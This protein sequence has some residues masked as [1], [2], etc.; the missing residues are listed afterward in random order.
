MVLGQVAEEL[1][2]ICVERADGAG[3]NEAVGLLSATAIP[4]VPRVA[5]DIGSGNL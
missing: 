5:P 2:D 4:Q 1:F 3:S